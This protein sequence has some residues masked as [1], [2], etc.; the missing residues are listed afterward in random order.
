M[1][2]GRGPGC[3]PR[4]DNVITQRGIMRR[5]SQSTARLAEAVSGGICF[6]RGCLGGW[7]RNRID[8]EG[9]VRTDYI[10]CRQR[11]RLHIRVHRHVGKES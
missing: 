6:R 10:D 3:V 5:G 2:M 7:G 4:M 9:A 8:S 1:A 11:V